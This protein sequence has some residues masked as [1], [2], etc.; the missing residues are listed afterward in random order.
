MDENVHDKSRVQPE[1]YLDDSEHSRGV[2]LSEE[3]TIGDVVRSHS[4]A[5]MMLN[6][7]KSL[8]NL[9]QTTKTELDGFEND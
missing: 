2:K 8:S 5:P 4:S 6:S 3:I 9:S 1:G 7:V